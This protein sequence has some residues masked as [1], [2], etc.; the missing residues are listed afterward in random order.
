[1]YLYICIEYVHVHVIIVVRLAFLQLH[2]SL[3]C[4]L[5][6]RYFDRDVGCIREFFKRRFNYESELFPNFTDVV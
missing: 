2:S 4:T 1:M 3:V 5:V 6:H